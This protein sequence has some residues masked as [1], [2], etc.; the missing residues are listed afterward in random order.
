MAVDTADITTIEPLTPAEARHLRSLEGRVERSLQS[1]RDVGEALLEIRDSRLYRM[2]HKTFEDYCRERWFLEP[3]RAHQF[4]GAAEVAKV[5]GDGV[6][7]PV[8]E[9]QARELVPLVHTRP[10]VVR[11][12]WAE[13]QATGKPITANVVREVVQARTTPSDAPPGPTPTQALVS[14]IQALGRAYQNWKAERPTR[15]EKSL[16]AAAL[17]QLEDITS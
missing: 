8:N 2:T 11:Q 17:S 14:R 9:A 6:E 12:V 5:L 4:M 13:V 16:V 10:E 7:G 3:T 15:Q 1:F